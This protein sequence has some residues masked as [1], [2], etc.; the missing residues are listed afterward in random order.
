MW[1]SVAQG[2]KTGTDEV[3]GVDQIKMGGRE[4]TPPPRMWNVS[5]GPAY[6]RSIFPKHGCCDQTN[7]ITK[8]RSASFASYMV[9]YTLNR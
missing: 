8:I 9:L 1:L 2:R 3:V 6:I 5:P 7:K 4:V